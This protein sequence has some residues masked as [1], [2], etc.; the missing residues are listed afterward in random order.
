MAEIII[1]S[2]YV[3]SLHIRDEKSAPL[4]KLHQVL[5]HLSIA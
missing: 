2:S 5:D 1:F 3:F 4:L